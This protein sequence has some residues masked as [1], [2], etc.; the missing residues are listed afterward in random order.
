M[1]QEPLDLNV[2]NR[3]IREYA[4]KTP[5][6]LSA[7]SFAVALLTVLWAPLASAFD[8][9]DDGGGQGV[10][11]CAVCHVDLAIA[12][13]D[14]AAHAALSNDDCGSCHDG[15]QGFDNPPLANCV[16]C[17]GRDADAGGDGGISDG[18]GRG[19]RRR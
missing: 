18:V 17:H 13:P 3:I 12:D 9:F 7:L 1:W 15:G 14:H 5:I 16:R 6:K 11:A 19:L 8:G 4:M 10:A 2:Q